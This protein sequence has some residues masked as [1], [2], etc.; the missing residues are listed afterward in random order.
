MPTHKVNLR[1]FFAMHEIANAGS[2]RAA[3]ESV[4]M[5]Q[6]ALTRVLHKLDDLAGTP[7]FERSGFGVAETAAG[8][9]LVRRAR[10]AIA[11]LVDAERE[12][13][14]RFPA[15]STGS[16][17]YRHVTSSQL[18]AL[19]AVVETGGYSTAA[20][21]LGLAQPTVHRAAKE[22]EKII[23]VDL[24]PHA[25]RG[26]EPSEAA[27][28][29]ARSAQLVF[30]EIRQGFEEVKELQGTTDSRIAVGCLP[31]ARSEFLPTAI[32]RL[33]STYPDARVSIL[34]GPYIEQLHAL[35]YG[36]ID[37]L[38]GALRQP[39][40]TRD[41]IQEALFDQPLVVVVRPG[42]PLL[43][44]DSP[45]IAE[46]AKLEWV[47][48]RSLAPAREFFDAL[49]DRNGVDAPTRIIECS[50]LIATRGL[51]RQSDRAALL[52]PLQVRED[53]SA[54]DLAILIDAIP[55]SSRSIGLTTRDNWEPTMVQAE[56]VKIV[57]E[58]A[59]QIGTRQHSS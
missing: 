7:L 45:D 43:E 37:W 40:P 36:Q 46:L 9:V 55:G 10:R 13:R 54:G 23:G 53:V 28:R 34:D 50:S 33:L 12:I 42:H 16:P 11:L 22:L 32:T 49:F 19:V 8:E 1:H 5:S 21:R 18:H 48:P 39:V 31:L 41:V 4:F 26:V 52:S 2:I 29:L 14:A 17:L 30:A 20:R 59:S 27:R 25:A 56:F 3:A 57:R 35:R 38:L 47:A 58:L 6:P 24:F 51:L 44:S 15:T